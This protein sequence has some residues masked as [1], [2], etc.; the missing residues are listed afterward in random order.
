M[1]GNQTVQPL[2]GEEGVGP[3]VEV[4]TFGHAPAFAAFAQDRPQT[5]ANPA[6]QRGEYKG[7]AVL[8]VC[9]PT[10][11]DAIHVGD[12]ELQRVAQWRMPCRVP[13]KW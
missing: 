3:T 4:P 11:K 8:E 6:V 10:P 9:K 13:W 1:G 12:D 7:P 5:L 2:F